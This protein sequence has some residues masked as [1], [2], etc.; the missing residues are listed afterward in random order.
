[1]K[2]SR[3]TAEQIAFAHKQARLGNQPLVNARIWSA[4]ANRFLD[5]IARNLTLDP[6]SNRTTIQ[7]PVVTVSYVPKPVVGF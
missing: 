6:S 7:L 2:R 1:M 5:L 3:F 4:R